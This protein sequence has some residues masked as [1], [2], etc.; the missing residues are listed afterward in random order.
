MK[1]ASEKSPH[2]PAILS[3]I[4]S[5][6]LFSSSN[7]TTALNQPNEKDLEFAGILKNQTQFGKALFKFYKEN[8][9]DG[10]VLQDSKNQIEYIFAMFS[11]V[12]R[13][14]GWS[15]LNGVN[16]W[17]PIARQFG[18]VSGSSLRE[19]YEKYLFAFEKKYSDKGKYDSET[20]ETYLS[21]MDPSH[22]KS[23][24]VH[25]P[26]VLDN[27]LSGC[28]IAR[29]FTVPAISLPQMLSKG[30]K[31]LTEMFSKTSLFALPFPYNGNSV[32][33]SDL[34][35]IDSYYIEVPLSSYPIGQVE[36]STHMLS[37]LHWKS[38]NNLLRFTAEE[39]GI[40]SPMLIVLK[41]SLTCLGGPSYNSLTGVY[42]TLYGT[43]ECYGI[44]QNY[45]PILKKKV[46]KDLDI[47][48]FDGNWRPSEKYLLANGFDFFFS[49]Q[50]TGDIMLANTDIV[51][52]ISSQSAVM[53]YWYLF[54][55]SHISKIASAYF[56][57]ME[58][59]HKFNLPLLAIEYL[60]KDLGKIDENSAA[61]LKKIITDSISEDSWTGEY[62]LEIENCKTCGVC[63]K[64]LVWRY[65]KCKICF[66]QKELN[67][68]CLK[69]ARVH[70]CKEI[71]YLEKFS[72]LELDKLFQRLEKNNEVES[73]IKQKVLSKI[74][75]TDEEN[76]C[77]DCLTFE[78]GAVGWYDPVIENDPQV[79][80]E[81]EITEKKED[82]HF[83]INIDECYKRKGKKKQKIREAMENPLSG[84]RFNY[85]IEEKKNNEK[86]QISNLNL[87][88][89]P[90][91]K[92][93]PLS[94]L[95][96]AQRDTSLSGLVSVTRKKELEENKN[97]IS[98]KVKSVE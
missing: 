39:P 67:S 90:I 20:V 49:I 6:S 7:L 16:N 60:N 66:L 22:M 98:E 18:N 2:F 81:L 76:G 44:H 17:G 33:L 48:I 77:G 32:V 26:S 10:E 55:E 19:E 35:E 40:N 28:T 65:A 37:Q 68:L 24:E 71:Q 1:Q 56:E 59:P 88:I 9:I 70:Q 50:T 97:K 30:F 80:K 64:D 31:V 43:C 84:P 14:G 45:I 94:G 42:L 23:F 72:A 52:W 46:Q 47:D 73:L 58:E 83:M 82:K 29:F 96:R 12:Y 15:F 51:Y 62:T 74:D 21:E 85:E 91:K 69:C 86:V 38:R 78:I 93:N 79:K 11:A 92:K 53:T 3:K 75:V 27:E 87:Q 95:V 57:T 63:R 36:I 89:Q 61:I 34:E 4:Q 54:P 41:N 25:R 13:N 5:G 8:C